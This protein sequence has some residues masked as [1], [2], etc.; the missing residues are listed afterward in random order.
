M[1]PL[2]EQYLSS[3]QSQSDFCVFHQIKVCTFHYWL[4]KY[5]SES[6]DGSH[7]SS[8]FVPLQ[9]VDEH[10][11]DYA[12]EIRDGSGRH[13]CFRDLPPAR[14]LKALLC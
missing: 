3:G 11:E 7:P 6:R 12:L 8:G 4:G 1:Y 2:I 13:L 14:Y 5:R 9:V 10:R